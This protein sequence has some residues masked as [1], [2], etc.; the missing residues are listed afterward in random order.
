MNHFTEIQKIKS[1]FEQ[2]LKIQ[3]ENHNHRNRLSF[4]SLPSIKP[5]W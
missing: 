2:Y 4:H 3:P 5:D 1:N